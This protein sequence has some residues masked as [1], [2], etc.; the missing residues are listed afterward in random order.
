MVQVGYLQKLSINGWVTR[1]PASGG[2]VLRSES[3]MTAGNRSKSPLLTDKAKK[4]DIFKGHESCRSLHYS[5][6]GA[7]EVDR[8][9]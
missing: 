8:K 4:S 6:G 7:L 3:S 9:P 2:C 5:E 1:P